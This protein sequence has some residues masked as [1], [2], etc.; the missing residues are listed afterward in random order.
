MLRCWSFVGSTTSCCC[1]SQHWG[2]LC[3]FDVW[4]RCSSCTW[5]P[6]VQ[7]EK[8]I[9]KAA[10]QMHTSFWEL[11]NKNWLFTTTESRLKLIVCVLWPCQGGLQMQ[12]TH[13]GFS[14]PNNLKFENITILG[15][16]DSAISVTLFHPATENTTALPSPNFSY[17]QDKKVKWA[18]IP[19]RLRTE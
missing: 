16:P 10:W 11:K 4:W 14:D 6:G 2:L 17:D 12:V 1:S 3:M 13:A 8:S 18:V 9:G 7:R 15:V 5:A 19:Q